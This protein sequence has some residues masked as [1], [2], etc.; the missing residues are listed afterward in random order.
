[1]IILHLQGITRLLLT[2]IPHYKDVVLM[3][4]ECQH[5]G[6]EN[7]E[8]QSGGKIAERGMKITLRVE[9]QH[10]LNRQVV[11]SDY[12]S[13]HIPHL[14]FE[15]PAQSQKGEITTIEGIIDRSISALEQ[16][17][18]KRREEFPDTAIE[19]DLFI[20]KLH[21][22]KVLDE[23]FTIIFEDISGN[24]HI[25]NPKAPLKDSQCTITYFK[26]TK[27]QNQTLGIYSENEDV[28]LKPIKEGEYPLEQIEGEVLSFPTNCPE[29]N[30]PCETNMKLT[31]I[32]LIMCSDYILSMFVFFNSSLFLRNI[33]TLCN[34]L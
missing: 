33:I 4:F 30:N 27:E 17:Q 24:S 22:L 3:S 16:D 20:S 28:L 19:L 31:S 32:L 10:D 23:P 12:T 13:I 11:K 2:K 5:C 34:N 8:I 1:M 26:R 21:A 15:I 25:E 29:C 14:D 9:T 18:P 7:N 6:Y